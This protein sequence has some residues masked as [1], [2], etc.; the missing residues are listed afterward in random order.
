[1]E[2]ANKLARQAADLEEE[3][4]WEEAANVHEQAAAA[5]KNVDM[6]SFD[7]VATMTLSSLTNRH[8]RWAESCRR[9]SSRKDIKV[10]I[11]ER[12][13]SSN[14]DK[15]SEQ[16]E[17]AKA[18]TSEKT[19]EKS[20]RD[21]EDFWQYMQNWL[22]DPAAFT[23][24][25]V[26]H[27]AY[28]GSNWNIEAAQTTPGV[29]ESFYLVGSNPDQSITTAATTPKAASPLPVISEAD[30]L[31]EAQPGSGD[32]VALEN[33]RLLK[34]VQHLNER[35]RTLESAAHENSMLKS[36]IFNFREEFH[37]HANA[38]SL[39]RFHDAGLGSR[40]ESRAAASSAA[41]NIRIRQLELELERVQQENAKQKA[42]VAKYRERWERLKESAKRKRQQ[43]EQLAS[44]N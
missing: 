41:S 6:F 32:K 42:Q 26:M 12:E 29:M 28:S 37:R 34:L 5:Y 35:I 20:E 8:M 10:A 15:K 39:S 36:S 23:R 14:L 17:P 3:Q 22:A 19:A 31:P 2:E 16:P 1:M 44:N 43:Q 40:P 33:Q 30:E 18:L 38:V 24:P 7:P 27:G 13:S 9:E 11:S 21:F 25:S 4:K